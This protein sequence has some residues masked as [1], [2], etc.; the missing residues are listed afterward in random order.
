MHNDI[1]E[2]L[3]PIFAEF[4]AVNREYAKLVPNDAAFWYREETNIG[5]LAAAAW[6]LGG[7]A[8]S[9]YADQRTCNEGPYDGRV[10]LWLRTQDGASFVIEAKQCLLQ[11]STSSTQLERWLTWAEEDA[12]RTPTYDSAPRLGLLFAVAKLADDEDFT[13][14]RATVQRVR[15]LELL[16]EATV[17]PPGPRWDNY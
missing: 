12:R 6:R 7:I 14:L 11:S 3:L 5:L 9:E 17:E 1:T 8:L 4:E 13:S 10:D 2:P 15:G 16:A